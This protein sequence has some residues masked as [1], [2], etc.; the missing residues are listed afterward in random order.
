MSMLLN[1]A[2]LIRLLRRFGYRYFRSLSTPPRY[3]PGTT[4]AFIPGKQVQCLPGFL[5][6]GEAEAGHS[7]R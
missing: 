1:H 5:A 3:A 4:I 6:A 2:G 7:L